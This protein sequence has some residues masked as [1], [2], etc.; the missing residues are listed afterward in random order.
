MCDDKCRKVHLENQKL[1]LEQIRVLSNEIK[2]WRMTSSQSQRWS[3]E[4]FMRTTDLC[5]WQRS[6][7]RGIIGFPNF[8]KRWWWQL[9]HK[10]T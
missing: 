1:L 3:V 6:L 2:V 4:E 10:S 8:V 7:E 5:G 9:F